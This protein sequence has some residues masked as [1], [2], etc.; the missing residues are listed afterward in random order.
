M[1]F[2]YSNIIDNKDVGGLTS[3]GYRFTMVG[4][5]LVFSVVPSAIKS[6]LKEVVVAI[7]TAE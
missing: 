3:Q 4:S 2:E 7:I 5:D 1:D 6:V